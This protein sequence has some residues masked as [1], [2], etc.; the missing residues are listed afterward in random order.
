M[1]KFFIIEEKVWLD[2]LQFMNI[3]NFCTI[4][5]QNLKYIVIAFVLTH[6]NVHTL[7][8]MQT[9]KKTLMTLSVSFC[10]F[11]VFFLKNCSQNVG[12]ID[13]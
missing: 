13:P 6:G 3:I 1:E 4:S 8:S 9:H 5:T 10:A 12:K 2:W 7:S 11:G